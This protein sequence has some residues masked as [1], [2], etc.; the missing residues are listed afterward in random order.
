MDKKHAEHIEHIDMAELP[1]E[2]SHH[3]VNNDGVDYRNEYLKFAGV[4]LLVFLGAFMHY[5]TF[6]LSGNGFLDSFMGVFFLTF[7]SFK[8]IGLTDFVMG[9]QDYDIIAKKHPN[10][11]FLYPFI[12]LFFAIAYL[13][14]GSRI[15][16]ILVLTVSLVSAYGVLKSLSKKTQFHCVCL[17]NVIKLPLNRVSLTEDLSMA[18]M[19]AYMLVMR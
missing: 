12:Q 1:E 13:L 4:L 15:I 6:D 17:G 9:F 3:S 2:A 5:T 18:A 8:L 19:A 16:D 14:G 11:G 7:A 10:Y